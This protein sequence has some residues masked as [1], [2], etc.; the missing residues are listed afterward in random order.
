M[1]SIKQLKPKTIKLP[2]LGELVE[3]EILE[4]KKNEIYV[5]LN[6]CFTGIIRGPEIVDASGRY[7]NLKTGDKITATVIAQ[8]NEK[9]MVE[10]SLRIA[11]HQRVWQD[12]KEI[13][14]KEDIVEVLVE[15]ANKG[16][17]IV[18][19]NKLSGFLPVSHLSPSHYPKVE[20]GNK[21][22]ILEKLQKLIGQ[23]LKVKILNIDPD[24]ETIIFSEKRKDIPSIEENIKEKEMLIGQIVEAQVVGLTN[25][26]AFVTFGNGQEGLIHISELSWERIEKVSD[27]VKMGDKLK[28]KV[29]GLNSDGKFSLSL[30][31]ITPN[32]W[33]K[34]A[35][36]YKVGDIIQ[37]K[38]TKITPFGIFAKIK[39]GVQGLAHI[40]EL[41]SS[42]ADPEE[43]AKVG[44]TLKFKIISL[45]PENQRL[46][47]SLK[48]VKQN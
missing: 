5:D 22:K 48:D 26:G 34:V 24:K 40:S 20:N 15:K 42:S 33:E 12:L 7:S 46:G 41:S 11:G 37:A 16:G 18:L 6:G 9:G 4:M 21:D 25:F 31:Q 1:P 43:V 32:P 38:V 23:K 28:A 45:E 13:A 30:K 29:I 27:A 3:G 35:R 19:Y 17:L 44:Q 47:L 36:S 8:D 14:K 10:L 2:K 39:E